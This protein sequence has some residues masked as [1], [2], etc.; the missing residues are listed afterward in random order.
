VR[1]SVRAL[2]LLRRRLLVLLARDSQLADMSGGRPEQR[3]LAERLDR[4]IRM[5]RLCRPGA[6]L[7]APGHDLDD[8]NRRRNRVVKWARR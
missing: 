2:L 6:F 3:H 7:D 4:A 8:P 1:L 5:A